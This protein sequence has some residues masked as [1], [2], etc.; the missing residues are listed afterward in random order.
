MKLHS[1]LFLFLDTVLKEPILEQ[2]IYAPGGTVLAAKNIGFCRGHAEF[3]ELG[4]L[5]AI[6]TNVGVDLQQEHALTP[7]DPR[8]PAQQIL[9]EAFQLS[10]RRRMT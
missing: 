6:R 4:T 10:D 3:D 1:P 2:K 5:L 7:S 9:E 8:T